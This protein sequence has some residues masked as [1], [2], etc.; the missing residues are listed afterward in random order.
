MKK[1]Y[2]EL[3]KVI[4]RCRAYAELDNASAICPKDLGS[5]LGLDQIFSYFV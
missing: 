4:A 3:L 1:G 5:S 2:E